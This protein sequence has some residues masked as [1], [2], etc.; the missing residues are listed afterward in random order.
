MFVANRYCTVLFARSKLFWVLCKELI[1][2]GFLLKETYFLFQW[3]TLV[4]YSSFL[5]IKR[6]NEVLDLPDYVLMVCTTAFLKRFNK[7]PL[8][9]I[10]NKNTVNFHSK[11]FLLFFKVRIAEIFNHFMY[12]QISQ[13]HETWAVVILFGEVVLQIN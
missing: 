5:P 2:I 3:W 11:T 8:A 12:P 7:T 10:F 13:Q 9:Y 1:Q 6:Y 4:N